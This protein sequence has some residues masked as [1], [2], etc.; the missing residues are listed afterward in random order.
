ME[1]QLA[2]ALMPGVLKDHDILKQ[3][4]WQVFVVEAATEQR[5]IFEKMIP[6]ELQLQKNKNLLSIMFQK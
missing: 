3:N 4:P 5:F 1:T 2:L 6:L